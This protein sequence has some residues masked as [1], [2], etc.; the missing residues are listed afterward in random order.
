MQAFQIPNNT[1]AAFKSLATQRMFGNVGHEQYQED[2]LKQSAYLR[3]S[4]TQVSLSDQGR[5]LSFQSQQIEFGSSV[6][7]L[8]RVSP[9]ANM[10]HPPERSAETI[11]GFI[12]ARINQL[13]L[14]GASS[15]E[16][17]K[18]LDQGLSGFRQ[19]RDEAIEILEGYGFMS[20]DVSDGIDKTTSLVEEGIAKLREQFVSD[21]PASIGNTKPAEATDVVVS[22]KA[23]DVPETF[24]RSSRSVSRQSEGDAVEG[25]KPVSQSENAGVSYASRRKNQAEQ[26][27]YQLSSFQQQFSQARALSFELQT[28]DGDRV[29]I[30]FASA[31]EAQAGQVQAGASR[32]A[33]G[34]Q[35]DSFVYAYQQRVSGVSGFQLEISGDLDEQEL[36]AIEQL[37]SD[38]DKLAADFFSGDMQSAFSKALNM[39]INTEELAAFS[40]RLT[41]AESVKTSAYK[42][43]A[44]QGRVDNAFVKDLAPVAGS[45]EA[46]AE[47]AVQESERFDYLELLKPLLAVSLASLRGFGSGNPEA[48][49]HLDQGAAFLESLFDSSIL[50][51]RQD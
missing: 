45:I 51:H 30:S 15:E 28:R 16:L 27:Q 2:T 18:T 40:L 14:D 42:D 22:P 41:Q 11:L 48:E 24:E 34:G 20:P 1:P 4:Q 37:L 26:F 46:L 39:G 31:L 47:R 12:E 5:Q 50:R 3:Y 33:G 7:S 43:M 17:N 38:V 8:G 49:K 35:V 29:T 44:N 21:D 23:A 10:A 6:G 19:G 9:A 32:T 25:S 13:S 36:L